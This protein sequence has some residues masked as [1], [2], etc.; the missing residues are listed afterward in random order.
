MHSHTKY[1]PDEDF[2]VVLDSPTKQ[3]KQDFAQE[4]ELMKKIGFSKHAHVVG[5]FGCVT[6]PEPVCILLEYLEYGDLL[7]YLQDINEAVCRP[8]L[9]CFFF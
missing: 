7:S 5:L 3:E 2:L 8:R 4:I 1:F 9:Q 6:V